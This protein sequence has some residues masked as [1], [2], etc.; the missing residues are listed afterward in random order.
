MGN[1]LLNESIIYSK[2]IDSL[3]CFQEA[4]FIRL[5][6]TVD[7]FGRYYADP[8]LL[9]SSLF[10]MKEDLTK[11]SVEDALAKMVSVGLVKTYEVDEKAYLQICDWS[12]I[13]HVRAFKSQFPGCPE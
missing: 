7:D 9:K 5:L 11:A 3:S 12:K 1:R 4:M 13:H 2:K 8:Q 6:V 10:P